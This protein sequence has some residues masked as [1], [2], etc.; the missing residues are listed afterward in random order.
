MSD[1]DVITLSLDDDTNSLCQDTSLKK[2]SEHRRKSQD[3]S[4]RREA[5]EGDKHCSNKPHKRVHPVLV[6][7]EPK[8]Q[9]ESEAEF[10]KHTNKFLPNKC[11]KSFWNFAGRK[12]K[13]LK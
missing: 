2:I 8:I 11:L 10:L 1:C 7:R 13:A 5:G 6:D 9:K 3:K 12:V 4:E